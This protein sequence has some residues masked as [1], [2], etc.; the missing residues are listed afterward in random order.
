M[1]RPVPPPPP[2]PPNPSPSLRGTPSP[3]DIQDLW[4]TDPRGLCARLRVGSR[5]ADLEPTLDNTFVFKTNRAGSRRITARQPGLKG[6]LR[7]NTPDIKYSTAMHYK[8][9]ATR[10]RRLIGLDVRI[11][12][13]WLLP[14]VGTLP[15]QPAAPPPPERR[16]AAIAREKLHDLL[17]GTPKYT[18]L[19]RTVE[20]KL[21][22]MRMVTVRRIQP[23]VPGRG[24]RGRRGKNTMNPLV[25]RVAR[26]GLVATV[27]EPRSAA[28]WDALRKIL[29]EQN[30]DPETRR[31]QSDIRDWLNAPFQA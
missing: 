15:P 7:K 28:F 1:R 21:G 3:E 29:G 26:H 19:V 27:D 25:S 2:A 31:L 17:S 20:Q 11:P 16:A 18:H 24:I 9:L 8:K 30:P 6:W 10:L 4:N 12:L 13:E 14:D 23:P 22:I 5:L